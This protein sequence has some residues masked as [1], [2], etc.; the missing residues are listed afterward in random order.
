MAKTLQPHFNS[1]LN[2]Q[3]EI[4]GINGILIINHA[5]TV[6]AR[7]WLE[8][9]LKTD[10]VI[11]LM[12]EILQVINNFSEESRLG[13][14]SSIHQEGTFGQ[15]YAIKWPQFNLIIILAGSNLMNIGMARAKLE[16]ILKS[17]N[18]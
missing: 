13:K 5:Q 1:I 10:Q 4:P 16:R 14:F 6:L 8:T 2:L 3:N 18:G 7:K 17:T 11:S 12:Q 15:I 9:E